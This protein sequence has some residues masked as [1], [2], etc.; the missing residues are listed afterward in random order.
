MPDIATKITCLRNSKELRP[1]QLARLV[2]MER[3]YLSS[4]EHGKITNLGRKILQG[5]ANALDV[6][7][8]YL[9][10][11]ETE[12]TRSWD[13][14][15]IDQSL[16]LFIKKNELTEE[17]KTGLRRVSFKQSAPRTLKGWKELRDNLSAYS[18]SSGTYRPPKTKLK[19]KRNIYY[20]P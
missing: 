16:D 6:S 19:S 18:R 3:T 4:I 12:E 15:A 17:E 5:L 20:S 9:V 7:I 11:D 2:P 10:D 13:K 8:D 14:V 1:T